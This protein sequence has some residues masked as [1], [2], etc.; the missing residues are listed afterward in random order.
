[1]IFGTETAETAIIVSLLTLVCIT[2]SVIMAASKQ[3]RLMEMVIVVD[4]ISS[5]TLT[6]FEWLPTFTGLVIALVFAL[7]GAWIITGGNSSG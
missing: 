3:R 1:M 4:F 6:Y 7:F 2:V 5:L